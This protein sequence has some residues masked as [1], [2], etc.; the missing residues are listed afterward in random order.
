MMVFVI[1]Q[2]ESVI[3]THMAPPSWTYLPL[4]FPFH[5][6]RLSQ[7]WLWIPCFYTEL[8]LDIK[9]KR[10]FKETISLIHSRE[11]EFWVWDFS[12]FFKVLCS[13]TQSC[14]KLYANMECNP[15]GSSVHGIF[16]ERILE[17]VS[18][19]LSRGSSWPRDQTHVSCIG[20]QTL[21][22]WATREVPFFKVS[23]Y[24]HT[25]T[26]THVETSISRNKS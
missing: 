6:S 21:Y 8:P 2:H 20:R 16:Q 10:S 1:H 7:H 3:G 4:P 14:P 13:V 12:Y 26:H 24:K 9:K 19:F 15:P 17:W 22:H 18:I 25:H 23:V 5:P 11:F